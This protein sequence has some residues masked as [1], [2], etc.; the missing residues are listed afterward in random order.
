M[1]TSAAAV[2]VLEP[3]TEQRSVPFQARATRA[4]R[5]RLTVSVGINLEHLPDAVYGGKDVGQRPNLRQR[6]AD[7][8]S[9]RV[10]RL[11]EGSIQRLSWPRVSRAAPRDR[12]ARRAADNL[13]IHRPF[14]VVGLASEA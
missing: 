13:Q 9:R 11:C 10:V 5:S 1:L 2:A 8:G 12:V 7:Q 14:M 4:Y 3:G 6:H